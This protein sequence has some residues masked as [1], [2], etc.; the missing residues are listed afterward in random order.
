MR[1]VF[2]LIALV[3]LFQGAPLFAQ[4]SPQTAPEYKE[5]AFFYHNVPIERIYLYRLGYV[6]VYRKGSSNQF[7]QAYI[8]HKW[9]TE[10]HGPGELVYLGRG[11][12]WPSMTVYYE[13]GEFSHVRLRL[14]RDRSHETWNMIPLHVNIDDRFDVEGVFLEH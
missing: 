1:K 12:E 10:A 8:P 3:V 11:R 13:D 4:F 5:S 7:A 2:L 9:F 14:R 6:V